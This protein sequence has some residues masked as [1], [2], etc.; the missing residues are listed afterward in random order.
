MMSKRFAVTLTA[1]AVFGA[2]GPAL[3]QNSTDSNAG[4]T[5]SPGVSGAAGTTSSGAN[6]RGTAS[7]SSNMAD[8]DKGAGAT[9]YGADKADKDK[10]APSS[11]ATSDESTSKRGRG[12][13]YGHDREGKATG[14]HQDNKD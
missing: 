3:A 13:A 1:A 5:T 6:T 9:A 2:F 8:Q 12:D 11:G 7:E 14:L 10:G 4:A